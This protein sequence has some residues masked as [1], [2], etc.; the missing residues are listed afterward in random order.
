MRSKNSVTTVAVLVL[1]LLC[2]CSGDDQGGPKT[3]KKAKQVI[4]IEEGFHRWDSLTFRS[5]FA[6]LDIVPELGGKIMG[7][8]LGGYQLLWHDPKSEGKLY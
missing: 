1:V 8:E 4:T 5:P 3:A 7:Y 6:R 2:S